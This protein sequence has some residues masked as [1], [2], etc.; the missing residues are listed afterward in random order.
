MRHYLVVAA[1]LFASVYAQQTVLRKPSGHDHSFEDGTTSTH[2]CATDSSSKVTSF[3][4][5]GNKLSLQSSGCPGY[6]WTSASNPGEARYQCWAKTVPA[7]PIIGTTPYVVGVYMY[8]N[9]TGTNPDPQKGSI[10]MAVNGVTISGNT[11][12]EGRDAYVYEGMSF[13]TCGGH[14]DQA[15]SY[16][17]HAETTDGCV[18]TQVSGQHSPLFGIMAD[19]V[20][21]YGAYGDGGVAPTDLDECNGHVDSTHN[22]YHYHVTP[23]KAYPYL[24]N[25]LKGCLNNSN[26]LTSQTCTPQ[27]TQYDYSSLRSVVTSHSTAT[28]TSYTCSK[29]SASSLQ[30]NTPFMLVVQLVTAWVLVVSQSSI[31]HVK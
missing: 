15:Y 7:N 21:I 24:V 4:Y 6:D 19:G 31:F 8:K 20:P 3:T 29:S 27:A 10:G 18:Y 1:A 14:P 23:N 9:K 12:A 13:D 16:H 22:F 26:W 11:D 28:A 2:Y 17:Y 5:T 25:C 30:I